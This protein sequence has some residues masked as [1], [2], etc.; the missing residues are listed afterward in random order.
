MIKAI[1]F[2]YYRTLYLPEENGISLKNF[3]LLRELKQKGIILGLLS[4]K[5]DGREKDVL[6]YN[7]SSFFSFIRFTEK[8]SEKDFEDACFALG[9]KKEEVNDTFVS[10]ANQ[11]L[12]VTLKPLV[13]S[14]FIGNSHSAVVDLLS[15]DVIGKN[16][17]KVIAWYDN[18]YGYACRLID[19]AVFVGENC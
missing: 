17:V 16:M 2:D 8:K 1:I 5:E 13:S 9:V 19:L 7:L 12:G 4:K 18:E 6:K 3:S 11:Y 10:S 14:D 15:T